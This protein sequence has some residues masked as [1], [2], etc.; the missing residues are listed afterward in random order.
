PIVKNRLFYFGDFDYNPLGQQSVPSA[1]RRAPTADGY[2][3]FST[4]PGLSQTNLGIFK[5]YV[6]PAP[7]QTTT[8][9][10]CSVA[11]VPCPAANVVNVPIGTFQIIAPNWQNEYRW[12]GSLDFNQSERDQWRGRYV[13]NRVDLIDTN[14]GGTNL[15]VFFLNRPIRTSLI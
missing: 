2:N 4:I 5:Q 7:L 1:V 14:N 10:V 13:G 9:P 3:I 12:L 8:T 15:P 6:S 11:V